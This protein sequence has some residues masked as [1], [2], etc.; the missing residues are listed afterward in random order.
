MDTDANAPLTHREIL[1][2]FGALL[3]GM[4]LAA[5]DALG[6]LNTMA[7]L[8]RNWSGNLVQLAGL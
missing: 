7:L 3:S 5:L 6:G 2:V 4:F 1:V 8:G